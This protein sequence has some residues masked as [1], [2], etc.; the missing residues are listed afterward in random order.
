MMQTQSHSLSNKK[1][2]ALLLQTAGYEQTTE[3]FT[4]HNDTTTAGL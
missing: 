2:L 1:I 3:S 4:I